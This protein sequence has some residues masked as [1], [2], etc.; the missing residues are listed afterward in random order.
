ME[1]FSWGL[2]LMKHMSPQT[3]PDSFQRSTE[4]PPAACDSPTPLCCRSFNLS[5]KCFFQTVAPDEHFLSNPCGERFPYSL[6]CCFLTMG[7]TGENAD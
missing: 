4:A 1:D 2:M 7:S 6:K 5:P 3:L